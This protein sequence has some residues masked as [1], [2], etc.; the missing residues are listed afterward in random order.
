L[1]KA[2]Q[3]AENANK[4]I[5]ELKLEM[6]RQRKEKDDLTKMLIQEQ[7]ENL[8]RRIEN[9]DK[10]ADENHKIIGEIQNDLSQAEIKRQ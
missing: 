3:D 2:R 10:N 1:L 8:K 5:E 6:E 7:S 9:I 4:V